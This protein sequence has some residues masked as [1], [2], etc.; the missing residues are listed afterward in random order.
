MYV[1]IHISLIIVMKKLIEPKPLLIWYLKS[2]QQILH[3]Q[4]SFTAHTSYSCFQDCIE[5][6]T[7][8]GCQYMV[9]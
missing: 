6:V 8:R 1:Y 3:A 2:N 7:A 5:A 4:L 9:G